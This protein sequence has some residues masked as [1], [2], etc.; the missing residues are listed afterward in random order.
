MHIILL[1]SECLYCV[2]SALVPMDQDY[3]HQESDLFC[4]L[5]LGKIFQEKKYA[6]QDLDW[7]LS[8]QKLG[9]KF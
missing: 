6:E 8:G 7:D 5:Q 1:S 9:S 4:T 2:V 3:I